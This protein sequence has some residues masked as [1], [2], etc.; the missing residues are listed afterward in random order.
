MG[1]IILILLAALLMRRCDCGHRAVDVFAPWK[2]AAMEQC[3]CD[4]HKPDE[5]F[6]I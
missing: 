2:H 4:C 6:G 5:D 1:L 3:S